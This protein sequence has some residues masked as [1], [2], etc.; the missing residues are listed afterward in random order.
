[1][2]FDVIAIVDPLTREAQKMAQLLIVRYHI[3]L[4]IIYIYY[5]IYTSFSLKFII[6]SGMFSSIIKCLLLILSYNILSRLSYFSVENE[7][8]EVCLWCYGS[9]R[10]GVN[11]DIIAV[12]ITPKIHMLK[13]YAQCDC[14][15]K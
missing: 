5:M 4:N 9:T 10:L 12:P 13:P 2:S 6:F 15:W 1:M 11:V 8:M 7:M 14:V 3:L